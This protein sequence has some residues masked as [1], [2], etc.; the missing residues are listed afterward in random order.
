[1]RTFCSI[2]KIIL[3]LADLLERRL[4][5][6]P[7]IA[8]V[9]L[10]IGMVRLDQ[11]AAPGSG[12]P[13]NSWGLIASLVAISAVLALFYAAL[14]DTRTTKAVSRFSRLPWVKCLIAFLSTVVLSIA[15]SWAR[16]LVLLP[17]CAASAPRRHYPCNPRLP[18]LTANSWP[19]GASP[20]VIYEPPPA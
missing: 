13:A 5:A 19:S 18:L 20:R 11:L 16:G 15:S 8:A 2:S 4:V 10:M 9:V 3:R 14:E 1:M 7:V 17:A 12:D 6:V